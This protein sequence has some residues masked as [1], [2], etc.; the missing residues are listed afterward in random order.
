MFGLGL[1][2]GVRLGFGQV[3]GLAFRLGLVR[4]MAWVSI[5][6][7]VRVWFME[8]ISHNFNPKP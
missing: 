6:V 4:F 8:A 5:R 1:K 3:L 7:R 2:L